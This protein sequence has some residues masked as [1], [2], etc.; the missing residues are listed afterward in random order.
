MGN[1][2]TANDPL[3]PGNVYIPYSSNSP[4]TREVAAEKT[5]DLSGLRFSIDDFQKLTKGTY[6]A[7]DL[8]LTGSGKLDI[9]NNHKTWT[10][11]N[12][13]QIDAGESF[14]I[15]VAFANALAEAGVS[16]NNMKAI[17][18][19]LGLAEDNALVNTKALTPLTRQQVRKI[20]DK[21]INEINANRSPDN[22]LKA[23]SEL[24]AGY[25]EREKNE[26]RAARVAINKANARGSYTIDPELNNVLRVLSPKLSVEGMTEEDVEE[27]LEDIFELETSLYAIRDDA[28]SPFLRQEQGGKCKVTVQGGARGM[29]VT[30]DEKGKVAFEVTTD[31]KRSRISVGMTLDEM[32]GVLG[33]SHETLVGAKGTLRKDKDS[34]PDETK[35]V[36]PSVTRKAEEP[37]LKIIEKSVPHDDDAEDEPIVIGSRNSKPERP[38]VNDSRDDIAVEKPKIRNEEANAVQRKKIAQTNLDTLV[39][40]MA[41]RYDRIFKVSYEEAYSKIDEIIKQVDDWEE[42]LADCSTMDNGDSVDKL[43]DNLKD[44]LLNNFEKIQP[45]I[46]QAV[47][48][49]KGV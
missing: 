18:L 9:A 46:D 13:K 11:F 19:K 49:K 7:G 48:E 17:R 24:H 20:I 31:G 16:E 10:I 5:L 22:K 25:S 12:G 26:I 39:S 45:L 38:S 23:Y 42:Q 8:C 21:N 34:M 6:N 35:D 3:I 4:V 14:S 37:K 33:T 28:R 2:R 41:K 15:R 47:G 32:L 43:N 27:C 40:A 29:A 30:L 44:F 36:E 1:F